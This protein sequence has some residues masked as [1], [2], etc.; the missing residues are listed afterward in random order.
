M[1]R[2][3]E[4]LR[5]D[6]EKRKKWEEEQKAREAEEA[7]LRKLTIPYR[8]EMGKLFPKI[9]TLFGLFSRTLR[10]PYQLFGKTKA[11]GWRRTS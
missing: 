11:K 6:E 10:P 9:S 5:R 8:E 3:Q 4:R 1:Q 2:V 7:E